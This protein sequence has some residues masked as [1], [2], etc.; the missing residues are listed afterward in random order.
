VED[1]ARALQIIEELS[2]HGQTELIFPSSLWLLQPGG[3]R[4]SKRKPGLDFD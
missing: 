4:Q 3:Y 2:R 1:L